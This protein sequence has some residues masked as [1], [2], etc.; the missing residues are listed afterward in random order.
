MA[1][2]T[3]HVDQARR[4]SGRAHVCWALAMIRLS[5]L[6]RS[7]A[8]PRPLPPHLNANPTAP[9][10]RTAPESRTACTQRGI[11]SS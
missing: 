2:F 5:A 3:V 9:A 8:D 10:S 6:V 7:A 11:G 4:P 1:G